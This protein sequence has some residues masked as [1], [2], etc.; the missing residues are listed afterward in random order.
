MAQYFLAIHIIINKHKLRR[1]LC[2]EGF[3]Q[4]DRTDNSPKI[5]CVCVY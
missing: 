1:Y 3:K 5:V 2:K 4:I